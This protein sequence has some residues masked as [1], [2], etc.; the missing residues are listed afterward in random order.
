MKKIKEHDFTKT[1]KQILKKHFPN[2]FEEIFNES[3]LIYYLNYK[4]KAA[5]KGSK[6][7]KSF[8][9]LYAIYT[10]I[11]DYLEFKETHP[12]KSYSEYKGG[13][14]SKLKQTMNN[15]PFG[16][17][18][19]NHAL[20]HRLNQEFQKVINTENNLIIRNKQTNRYWINENYLLIKINDKIYN[21][22]HAVI[23][24]INAYIETQKENFNE[25][26]KYCKL[27]L[28]LNSNNNEQ[29]INFIIDQLKPNVDARIFEI[30]SFA[31]LK[32]FYKKEC[33][34]WKLCKDEEF[35]KENLQL[36]KTGRTNA[37]DGGIDFVMKPLGRFF[38]VTEAL[39]FKKYFLDIDK[40][41]KYPIT[42]VIKTEKPIEEIKSIIKTQAKEQ[43]YVEEIVNKYMNAIEEIININV[44][45]EIL[46]NL[47][48]LEVKQI[49]EDIITYSKLEFNIGDNDKT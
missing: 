37:N 43:Y 47:N 10:V 48:I 3:D 28:K 9:N 17:K 46:I 20:N 40:I 30:V 27:L 18:L 41:E 42:F 39:D 8:A 2:N 11:K 33:V 34:E 22:A 7:R 6:A 25:F 13:Q 16:E 49:I 29:I 4:T 31:I 38:Q 45:K 24:I 14:Y 23:D 26:I 5:S 36:Y 12:N 44:L 1:I 15:L 35:Q 32:T 21:I 19:Q